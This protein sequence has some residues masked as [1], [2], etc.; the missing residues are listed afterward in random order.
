VTSAP[1]KTLILPVR[2][3]VAEMNSR[4]RALFSTA[5]KSTRPEMRLRSGLMLSGL[6]L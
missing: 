4:G 1:L 3:L 5:A 2:T 6:K